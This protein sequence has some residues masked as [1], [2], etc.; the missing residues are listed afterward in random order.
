MRRRGRI[1]GRGAAV[2]LPWRG[3]RAQ[4][5]GALF[6]RARAEEGDGLK[7]G[8]AHLTIVLGE[9]GKADELRRALERHGVEHAAVVAQI[10]SVRRS[11]VL[12]ENEFVVVC[13]AL[14]QRTIER[15]G[16]ALRSL[17]AD[18]RCFPTTV[19]TVGLLL[20]LG[21]TREAAQLG[22]DVYVEDSAQA[23]K[24]IRMLDNA[25]TAEGAEIAAAPRPPAGQDRMSI[26]RGWMFGSPR[27]P[28]EVTS[29]VPAEGRRG[30]GGPM[31]PFPFEST[32]KGFGDD[33][34]P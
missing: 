13:I 22:C 32:G 23:A 31:T 19:R 33:S 26:R 29:L 7:R 12:G 5:A 14:D 21:L 24:V 10:S 34:P 16:T 3:P 17:L 8:D 6:V 1:D 30:V 28:E 11:L 20:D 4:R 18:N 2:A 27:V 25:W 9:P 15:H